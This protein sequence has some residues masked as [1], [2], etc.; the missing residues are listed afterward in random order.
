MG[1]WPRVCDENP[2]MHWVACALVPGLFCEGL[3]PS[4]CSVPD[5]WLD[6]QSSLER[7]LRV[8]CERA[9]FKMLL[10]R[11]RFPM[12]KE[13]TNIVPRC[14]LGGGEGVWLAG[15]ES[16]VCPQARV[17]GPPQPREDGPPGSIRRGV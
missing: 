7:E 14:S 11:L 10:W 8:L 12:W 3:I 2:Q 1:L 15:R 4:N 17:A 9:F 16:S 5:V 13:R 6:K